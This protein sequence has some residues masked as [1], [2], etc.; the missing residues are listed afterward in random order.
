MKDK[1][2]PR[3]K[4]IALE[5]PEELWQ[6]AKQRAL[7]DGTNF[8]TVVIEALTRHLGTS[9]KTAKEGRKHAR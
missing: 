8:R 3:G 2:M 6:A 4:K 9:T 1:A 7:D 5:I